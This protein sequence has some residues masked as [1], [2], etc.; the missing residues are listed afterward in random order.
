[1]R[2]KTLFRVLLKFLGV[3][4]FIEGLATIAAIVF[5]FVD[6]FS[7]GSV[8]LGFL[9]WGFSGVVQLSAGLYLF[10]GGRWIVDMA[11]P[12]N[13]PFCPECGYDMS[14]PPG[15][16]CPEC[17]TPTSHTHVGSSPLG[18]VYDPPTADF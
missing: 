6:L 8:G 5:Q 1:M 13:R 12:S 17:G 18:S 14:S 10:F 3:W 16:Q 2:Y 15:P 7:V 11:I 4:L 9:G